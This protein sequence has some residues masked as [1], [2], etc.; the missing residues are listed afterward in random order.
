MTPRYDSLRKTD[1]DKAIQEYASQH[2]DLAHREIARQFSLSRSR[3]T[4]ILG[5]KKGE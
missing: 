1:R 3:I 4:Q 2:P 5:R